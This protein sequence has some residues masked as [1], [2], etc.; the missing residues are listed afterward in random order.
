MIITIDGPAG[1]G[2]STVA[3]RL[4]EK[5]SVRFLDTGA[6]Y[7]A[8]ALAVLKAQVR[9]DD[10]PTVATL[11][12]N[13][14]IELPTGGV[15]LNGFNVTT[16][17]REPEVTTVASIIA[18]NPAVRQQLVAMQQTIGAAGPIVTEGRDQGTVVFPNAPHKF[19]LTASLAARAA[20]RLAE[21]QDKSHPQSLEDVMHQIQ[22]RDERDEQR[23]TAPMKPAPDAV[24]VD[25]SS[26]NIDDVVQFLFEKVASDSAV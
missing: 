22:L 15:L 16:A 12:Q 17:I 26:M 14:R 21:L 11:A 9:P 7:R 2:K 10:S 1:S 3:R 24:I 25:T 8:I 4:A 23:A 19:F 5:L 13:C 20:R 6:M 18:A